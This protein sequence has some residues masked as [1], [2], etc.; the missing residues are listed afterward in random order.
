MLGDYPDWMDASFAA[1][2]GEGR[3]AEGAALAA[4]A[5]IDLRVNTLKGDI[6]KVEDA[7]G[8][9]NPVRT[10]WSSTGL[11]IAI[12]ASARSPALHV[13]PT[14]L[15]G[16]FEIQDEG[17]QV[18]ALLAAALPGEQVVD[19]CAGA[20]G[21]T[22]ALAAAMDSRGQ[23]FAT[24]HDKRR[25]APIYARIERAGIRN[26]QVIGPGRGGE[27]L[28][29][30][31]GPADLVVVDAPCTGTGA[32]RRNPDAKWRVRPSS[33]ERRLQEQVAVLDKAAPLVKPGGRL[34]YI[35]CSVLNEENG[36]QVRAFI[37]RHPEFTIGNPVDVVTALGERAERFAE[38]ALMSNE[39]VLMTPLRTNTDGFFVALLRKAS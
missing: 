1:L 14:F 24:D 6:S 36:H 39:G 7:L 29:A 4:R 27:E 26:A 28:A 37:Q 30:V 3:V 15:Q 11:R 12:S 2:F 34:A 35:T 38:A 10:P 23:L 8:E 32:W 21:K 33:L 5:P 13:E 9:Y 25:L 22:L 31:T 17:S 20:G 16:S 19:L 18:A